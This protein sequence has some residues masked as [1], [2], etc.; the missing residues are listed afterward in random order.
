MSPARPDSERRSP[1]EWVTFTV[2]AA[3][4]ALVIGLIAT[5]IPQSRQ[6]PSPTAEPG[7]VERRGE[8]YVVPVV[9]EN[10]GERTAQDVQVHVGL[11]VGG[12]EQEGDQ[13]IDFLSA[14]ER[15]ELEFVF[16]EDPTE[17]ALEVRVTGYALP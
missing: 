17:G 9:V 8:Q 5:E 14:G 4:V 2:A 12:E 1:A 16:D 15:E 7:V 11:T 6:P 13:V 3:L 10:E